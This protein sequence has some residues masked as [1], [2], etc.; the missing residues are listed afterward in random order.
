MDT[1]DILSTTTNTIYR[2]MEEKNGGDILLL[3]MRYMIQSRIQNTSNT[4][5]NDKFMMKAM[6]WWADR[7]QKAKQYLVNTKTIE[8][9]ARRDEKGIIVGHFIRV[10][11]DIS[12]SKLSEGLECPQPWIP[13]TGEHP[14]VGKQVT[15]TIV[16]NNINTIVEK[17][18]TTRVPSN[19]INT[20][21]SAMKTTLASK[22]YMYSNIKERIF[23]L[24][25]SKNAEWKA[26]LEEN[27][28]T[29][30]EALTKVMEWTHQD[31]F[32]NSK[33]SS[34]Q[35][36][37]YKW[38]M[39]VNKMKQEGKWRALNAKQEEEKKRQ[40]EAFFNSL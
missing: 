31:A 38:G 12:K 6:W 35:T 40:A 7:F 18:K 24:H 2:F 33:I 28:M 17:E 10:M 25:I 20:L 19:E 5:S 36:F 14:L 22:G 16:E 15:N 1:N 21:I 8:P 27:N 26:L 3:Y 29:W 37:Y 39:L 9:I 23:G 30:W 4:Y 32:W 13:T 34:L 11:F